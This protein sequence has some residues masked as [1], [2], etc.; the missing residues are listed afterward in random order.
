[1]C[2][3]FGFIYAYMC[4]YVVVVV[5]LAA[6]HLRRLGDATSR[7]WIITLEGEGIHT[8]SLLS[9]QRAHQMSTLAYGSLSSC[10]FV[11]CV[12]VVL[13]YKVLGCVFV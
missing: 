8:D 10:V 3:L 6:R 7:R 11:W 1:M 5:R 13:Y 12:G 4:M 2:V 9:D